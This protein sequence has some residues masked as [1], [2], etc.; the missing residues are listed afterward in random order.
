MGGTAAWVLVA[1]YGTCSSGKCLGE[2]NRV[3]AV[4]LEC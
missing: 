1:G 3:D 2:G 4:M